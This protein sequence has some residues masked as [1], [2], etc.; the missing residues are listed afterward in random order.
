[1]SVTT[2]GEKVTQGDF[3][4]LKTTADGIILGRGIA[5]TL[6]A[7]LDDN[8]SLSSPTGGRTTPRSSASSRPASR[9]SITRAYMLINNAQTLLD[10]KNI[11]NEIMIR[12]DDYT[13]AR[14]LAAQI[15]GDRRLQDRELAGGQRE[16]PQD[17]QDP[18]DHHLLHHRRAAGRRRVRRAEHPDHGGAGARERHRDPQEL[19]PLARGH[20]A[21]LPVPGPGD[22]PDRLAHRPGPRQARDRRTAPAADPDGRAREDRGPA[23]E[24]AREPVRHRVRLRDADRR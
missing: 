18:D 2:I 20:H 16:L 12:T 8:I 22:R 19:R 1:M 11:I 23:D 17:L 6:G 3:E 13:Q 5:L 7:K 9:R 21:D 24:R 10:K 15:E 4:R 14:E